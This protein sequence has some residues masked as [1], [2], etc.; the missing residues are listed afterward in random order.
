MIQLDPRG[1]GPSR[2]A[3]L[4]ERA[5]GESFRKELDGKVGQAQK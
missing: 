4:Q 1:A 3:K 2:R 5:S